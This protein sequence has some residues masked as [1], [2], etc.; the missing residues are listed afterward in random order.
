MA[1]SV[2]VAKRPL[3]A[4]LNT[5]TPLVCGSTGFDQ[6][7]RQLARYVPD[8]QI[9]DWHS[10]PDTSP[11]DTPTAAEDPERRTTTGPARLDASTSRAAHYPTMIPEPERTAMTKAS[12]PPSSA[13]RREGAGQPAPGGQDPRDEQPHHHDRAE[14]GEQWQHDESRKQALVS[15]A[16]RQPGGVQ[17]STLTESGEDSP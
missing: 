12:T 1:R 5:P 4:W 9:R 2:D 3:R 16:S 17:R 6:P 15:E 10:A 8:L 13:T 11:S 14:Q 7:W